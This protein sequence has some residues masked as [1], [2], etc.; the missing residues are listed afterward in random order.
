[1]GVLQM[2]FSVLMHVQPLV[3][4]LGHEVTVEPH[5][6]ERTHP[7]F[8]KDVGAWDYKYGPLFETKSLCFPLETWTRTRLSCWTSGGDFSD[9]G[10]GGFLEG[11][12][13]HMC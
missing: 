13:K 11:N 12:S 4:I 6:G 10:L 8:D 7:F 5:L 2:E 9:G 1:M 3:R